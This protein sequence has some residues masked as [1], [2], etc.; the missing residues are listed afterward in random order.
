MRFLIC[1]RP[2]RISPDTIPLAEF[3][4]EVARYLMEMG[5]QVL[6]LYT[7]RPPNVQE[8]KW[9]NEG[10]FLWKVWVV[11]KHPG[12]LDA[13]SLRRIIN[14]FSPDAVEFHFSNAPIGLIASRIMNVPC[15]IVWY[16]TAFEASVLNREV[17][18]WYLKFKVQRARLYRRLANAHVANSE[19]SK[20][21]YAS[22]YHIPEDQTYVHYLGISLPDSLNSQR[23]KAMVVCVSRLMP[24]KGQTVLI[25]C[26]PK[27]LPAFPNLKVIL[28]PA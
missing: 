16:H 18:S 14:G 13:F 21:E 27:L 6:L 19:F 7:Q 3:Q 28:N 12:L 10:G 17:P 2:P 25:Q 1:T 20:K 11:E 23:K 22:L 26:L 24:S 8:Q 5:H 15:R 9:L 4:H